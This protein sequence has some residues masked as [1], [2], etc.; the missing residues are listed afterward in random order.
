MEIFKSK[1]V[2]LKSH[3]ELNERWLQN[4]I[5]ADP[6]LLG[7]GDLV[8]R[9]QERTQPRGGRLDLL[10]EDPESETRFEVELQLGTVDE[11]HIIRTIEYWDLERRRYPQ[12]DHVAVIVA[13]EITTRF[14]NV[15][16]LFNGFIPLIAIQLNALEVNGFLTL[17]STRVLDVQ[18]LGTE[19]DDSPALTTDRPYWESKSS[20]QMLLVLD[21]LVDIAREIDQRLVA[22]YNKFYIG[23]GI[24]GIA[25]NFVSF[26]PRKKHVVLQIKIPESET[27]DSVLENTTLQLLDYDKRWRYYR[28][29]L[30]QADVDNNRSLLLDLMRQAYV[31]RNGI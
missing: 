8:V 1:V 30:T 17:N 6:S 10:L 29:Q 23:L 22:R 2:S 21:G 28:I 19:E 26:R 25:N 15:I 18:S 12:Y 4:Q 14:F 7:L 5:V 3:P 13:E 16:G 24:D 20:K 27:T 9:S 11:S 31:Q